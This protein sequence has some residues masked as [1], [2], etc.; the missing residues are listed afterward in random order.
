[1]LH[2]AFTHSPILHSID[3]FLP[4]CLYILSLPI[5]LVNKKPKKAK[6]T[7]SEAAGKPQR[8]GNSSQRN[9][10]SPQR[11]NSSPQRTDKKP[12]QNGNDPQRSGKAA[13]NNSQSRP[14]RRR[15]V[16][17]QAKRKAVE[18]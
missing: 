6:N 7:S 12:Q 3:K 18:A 11:N 13:D 2:Q 17:P 8:N 5:N 15:R 14:P 10:K 9:G 16:N 4:E 1:M